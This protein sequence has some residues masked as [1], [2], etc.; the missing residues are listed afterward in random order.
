MTGGLGMWMACAS[1]RTGR[2]RS[3]VLAGQQV[4]DPV[5]VDLVADVVEPVDDGDAVHARLA[6]GRGGAADGFEGLVHGRQHSPAGR[7]LPPAW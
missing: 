5:E 7:V 1:P 4:G 6:R 3:G 2:G